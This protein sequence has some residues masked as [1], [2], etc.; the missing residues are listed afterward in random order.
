M[1]IM[2]NE[3]ICITIDLLIF[4]SLLCAEYSETYSPHM[5]LASRVP[6]TAPG[7]G[8]TETKTD[9]LPTFL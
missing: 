4:E 8:N 1:V 6:G 2:E 7:P 3:R 5:N 9:K